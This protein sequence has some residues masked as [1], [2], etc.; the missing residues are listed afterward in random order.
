MLSAVRRA[1]P[2]TSGGQVTCYPLGQAGGVIAA[3]AARRGVSMRDVPIAE[4][5][6]EF[7][8]QNVYLGTPE[9]LAELGLAVV[10]G[11]TRWIW[12]QRCAGRKESQDTQS[13]LL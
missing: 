12:Y 3:L 13:G 1:S 11:S 6:R 7:L 10:S 4:V 2:R 5:Q 8:A 9:R